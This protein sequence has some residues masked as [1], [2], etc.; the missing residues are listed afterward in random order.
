MAWFDDTSV[1]ENLEGIRGELEEHLDRA[2]GIADLA[3]LVAHVQKSLFLLA[4]FGLL[5]FD[6][7]IA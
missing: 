1:E 2:V 5:D 7:P 6:P 4:H 3:Q